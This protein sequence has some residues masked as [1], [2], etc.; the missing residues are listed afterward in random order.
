MLFKITN[1]Y[2]SK[3]L[4]VAPFALPCRYRNTVTV[5]DRRS[6]LHTVTNHY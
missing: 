3:N 1:Y 4:T 6:S 2:N 5:I